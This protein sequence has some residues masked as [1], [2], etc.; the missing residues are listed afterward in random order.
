[1][2][3]SHGMLTIDHQKHAQ[4]DVVHIHTSCLTGRAR[5][6]SGDYSLAIS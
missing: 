2:H 5:L 6:T 3:R 4:L 1:M